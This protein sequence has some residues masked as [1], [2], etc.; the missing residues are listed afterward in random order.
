MEGVLILA[1]VLMLWSGIEG[2]RHGVIR[3]V[4]E[5][6]GLILV[7]LLASRLAAFLEPELA[8][9]LPISNKVAFF[10]SWTIVLIGGIWATRLLARGLSKLFSFSVIGWLDK[11]GG[12]VLG[13]AFGA[14][15]ASTILILVLA[16]PVGDDYRR[17][18]RENRWSNAL[19]WVAPSVYDGLCT[20]L[21]GDSFRELVR[22]HIEPT[23][24]EAAEEIK[25]F[26]LDAEEQSGDAQ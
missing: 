10:A 25:A 4:V 20:V 2:Y 8:E 24:R 21:P 7:F 3:R 18:I 19:L 9:R 11:G 1:G 6:V 26:F 12:F 13:V 15:L 16:L 23:A 22:D 14:I 17:E 5:I